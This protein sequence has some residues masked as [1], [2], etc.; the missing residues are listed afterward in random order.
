MALYKRV[1]QARGETELQ[2]LGEEIRDSYG[3]HVAE[4]DTLLRYAALRA[5]AEATGVSQVD[6]AGGALHVRFAPDPAL[7]PN[8]LVEFVRSR[9]GATLSPQGVLRV[10]TPAGSGALDALA[11]RLRALAGTAHEAAAGSL[12]ALGARR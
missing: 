10:P 3:P 11:G 2:T 12:P 6:F 1:S 9:A 8:A 5:A 7:A 4:V